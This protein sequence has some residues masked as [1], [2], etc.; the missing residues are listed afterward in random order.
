VNK[1]LQRR[2]AQW[3]N[4]R[5]PKRKLDKHVVKLMEEVGELAACITKPHERANLG[6]ELADVA[7]QLGIIAEKTGHTLEREIERKLKKNEREKRGAVA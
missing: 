5:Y 2:V 1:K 3:G 6:G 4:Q 7:I